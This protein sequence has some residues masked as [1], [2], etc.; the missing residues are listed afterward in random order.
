MSSS[1]KK[2]IRS[3]IKET[4]CFVAGTTIKTPNGNIPIED[5]KIGDNV[6]AANP[7]SNEYGIKKVTNVFAKETNTVYHILIENEEIVTTDEH[8]F[9]VENVGWVAAKDLKHGDILRLQNGKNKIVTDVFVKNLVEPITVFNFEV[10]DWH[11]YFVATEG[12]LVHNKCSLTKISDSY[13]KK[14]GFNAHSI[15]YEILGKGAKISKYNLFYDKST[16]A[17]FILANGAKET[18]KIATGYFIK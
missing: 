17:I 9:W 14:K 1:A 3:L 16:G 5:I 10:E 13:L 8:P 7:E 12:V 2:S 4:C 15:K 6:Y 11:T 18:A